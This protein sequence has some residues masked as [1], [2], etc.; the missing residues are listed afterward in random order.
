MPWYVIWRNQEGKVAGFIQ[1]DDDDEM[2]SEWPT[3]SAARE[4]MKGHILEKQ[5]EFIEL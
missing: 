1:E 4:T 5:C 2:P 3:E